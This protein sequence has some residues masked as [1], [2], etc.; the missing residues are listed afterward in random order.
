MNN[1]KSE[2]KLE[3]VLEEKLLEYKKT[4]CEITAPNRD[5]EILKLLVYNE[6]KH[7]KSSL[8]EFFL[9]QFSLLG[10]FSLL[11]ELIWLVAFVGL[12]YY[13][14]Y[15]LGKENMMLLLS[16]LSPLLL[17]VFATDLSKVLN[18]SI[19]EIEMTTKY[20]IAQILL[21]RLLVHEVIQFGIIFVGSLMGYLFFE[22]SIAKMLLYGY[23][24]L[25][26]ASALFLMIVSRFSGKSLQYAGISISVVF[27]GI[28]W[29]FGSFDLFY[30]IF[31]ERCMWIWEI[32]MCCSILLF[33]VDVIKMRK[34]VKISGIGTMR[35]IEML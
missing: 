24:P 29:M 31:E 33:A 7:K 15:F 3:N 6:K 21:F 13:S 34:D 8:L 11:W 2:R 27:I 1:R 12:M 18:K 25:I 9:G 5:E 4:T 30:T 17:I 16:A 22:Q 28:V 32:I 35:S 20:S 19:L 10:R 23:T 26:M 14:K